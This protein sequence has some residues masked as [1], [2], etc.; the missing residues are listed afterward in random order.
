MEKI[1]KHI[2]TTYKKK[3]YRYISFD[4]FFKTIE[5]ESLIFTR[6]DHFNDPLD[7]SRVL[8]G[9]NSK[10]FN[11]YYNF[12]DYSDTEWNEYIKQS[13]IPVLDSFYA[14]CFSKVYLEKESYLMWSHY[15]QSHT[16]V[17]F[18]LDFSKHNYYGGPKEINYL[19]DLTELRK[20]ITTDEKHI[21]L[22]L[23]SYKSD[24]WSY[25][26]EVRLII[27][28]NEPGQ[29]QY[30]TIDNDKRL[31]V[32]FNPKLIT[33]VIFGLKSSEKN[34]NRLAKLFDSIGHTKLIFEK[35]LINP[36]SLKLE[37]IV[38]LELDI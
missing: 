27:D 8:L 2:F 11:N 3:V 17:C 38:Y 20:N 21:G 15:G 1:K 18:E 35:M 30:K 23:I 14:C 28:L 37:S 9:Y 33:K 31:L 12:K 22:K 29:F 24:I 7:N 6:T 10:L 34:E 19:N 5:T 26:K 13:R 25:E 4:T 16:Q 36:V 32:P